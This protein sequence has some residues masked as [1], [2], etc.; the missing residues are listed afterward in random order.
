MSN[1]F[2]GWPMDRLAVVSDI[3]YFP[4]ADICNQYYRL[5]AAEY[6]Y[7]WPLSLFVKH[8][9]IS[10]EV[11]WQVDAI[12]PAL[13]SEIHRRWQNDT[14]HVR[15]ETNL[16]NILY[17]FDDLIGGEQIIRHL[18][19]SPALSKWT[20]G[21]CPDLIYTQAG[22]LH[23]MS[24]VRQFASAFNVPYV[25]HMMDDWPPTLYGDKVLAPYLRRRLNREFKDLLSHS[26]GFMGIGQ[27]MCEAYKERYERDCIPFHNPLQLESW[28]KSTKV[29]WQAG[30]PFRMMYRG[31]IGTSIHTSLLE[32]SNA[33]LQL[34]KDG[35]AIQFD[36]IVTPS[37]DE[38]TKRLLERPGCVS[39]LPA[40]PYN[41]VPASLASVD[42]LVLSYD[43][44]PD[45]IKFIRYSIPTKASEYMVS[46]VPILVYGANEL[47][48]V[49]YAKREHWG[50]VVSESN[51]D[52]LK[53]AINRLANDPALRERLGR[54]AHEVAL[55]NH[56]ALQVREAF[57]KALVDATC[58][59]SRTSE[60]AN[61]QR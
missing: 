15:R 20:N 41:D 59:K 33:V 34:Y 5:G 23:E 21:F 12:E 22:C 4:N 26:S 39:V 57:R 42:L 48:V 19:L 11:N 9:R 7:V 38:P 32:M 61:G 45:S 49:E 31:R 24:L 3:K 58:S 14:G 30:T 60:N 50:Y 13:F 1:L 27:K 28:V 55:R 47:A 2:K 10:G 29:D 40:V 56:D 53:L 46:G 54:R 18:K 36:I 52:L 16:W 51:G 37:C 25:I 6:K 17:K 43:F 35:M 8:R 44:D